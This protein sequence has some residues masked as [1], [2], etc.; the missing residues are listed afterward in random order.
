[1]DKLA[2]SKWFSAL[3]VLW[4]YHNVPMH[5]KSIEKTAFLAND[6]LLE[7][8]RMP[9]GL[10]NAPATSQ[11]MMLTALIGMGHISCTYL[12]DVLIHATNLKELLLRT[13]LILHRICAT[14]LKLKPRK[15]EFCKQ[16]IQYL[17]YIVG[18]DGVSP[19]EPKLKL[20]Q[21]WAVPTSLK[22][23]REFLG[24]INRH[25]TFYPHMALVAAPLAR[26]TRLK[27]FVRTKEMQTAFEVT[28]Q[29]LANVNTLAIIQE[30][31]ELILET[32][33]SGIG[34][35]AVLLQIQNGVE[36]PIAYYSKTLNNAERNY[37]VCKRE[38]FALVK[39]V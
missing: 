28:K 31:G 2:G 1:V 29:K 24:F 39:A 10:T 25:F 34:I 18:P 14:G 16:K 30:K 15:C 33:A 4:G 38:M 6:E 26:A 9:F 3:D 12:D 13:D 7:F 8:T 17:G 19:V 22:E 23:L 20:I 27:N 36:N 32:D 11:R 5:V 21:D 37:D 35:G